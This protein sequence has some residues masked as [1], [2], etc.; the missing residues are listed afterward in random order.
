MSGEQLATICLEESTTS[1][2]SLL[3]SRIL[4][5]DSLWQKTDSALSGDEFTDRKDHVVMKIAKIKE[6]HLILNL[7]NNVQDNTE[8]EI[9]LSALET[10]LINAQQELTTLTEQ[11]N[12]L[13]IDKNKLEETLIDNENE[14]TSCQ[15]KLEEELLAAQN[16]LEK[17]KLAHVIQ[18][19]RTLK[20]ASLINI[21]NKLDTKASELKDRNEIP[22]Y[23]AANTLVVALRDKIKDYIVCPKDEQQALAEFKQDIPSLISQADSVLSVHRK[24]W[25]YLLANLSMAVALLGVGYLAAAVANKA[26][27]GH[28]TFF[29]E[30]DSSR[31]L[32]QV[33]TV[34][35]RSFGG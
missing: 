13:V 33:N 27:T 11:N 19:E 21:L 8:T 26:L 12:Q 16:E 22:A 1:A 2:P 6:W 32:K 14:A 28:F 17:A 30:T 5:N 3:M 35:D 20:T 25:K 4:K 18:L 9:K 15:K 29:A 10:E 24:Q 34:Y 7:N 23:N 31:Q